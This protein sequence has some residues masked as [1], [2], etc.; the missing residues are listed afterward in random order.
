MTYRTGTKTR[1]LG[2][3]RENL[4]GSKGTDRRMWKRSG[5]RY[6]WG[7]SLKWRRQAFQLGRGR[8]I[9]NYLTELD[10]ILGCRPTSAP[11]SVVGSMQTTVQQQVEPQKRD[12]TVEAEDQSQQVQ[13]TRGNDSSTG[14]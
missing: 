3:K 14:E 11:D 4:D 13:D 6:E 12:K 10:A 7:G 1:R 5:S 9:L 2:E 8:S